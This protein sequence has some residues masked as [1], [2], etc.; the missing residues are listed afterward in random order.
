MAGQGVNVTAA[1]A[2]N[3]EARDELNAR[4][5]DGSVAVKKSG[6]IAIKG[7]DI[8]VEASGQVNCR[9]ARDM[10]LRGSRILQN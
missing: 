9:A 4:V 8:A 1:A 10:V 3:V 2:V 7:K 5:G 6:D